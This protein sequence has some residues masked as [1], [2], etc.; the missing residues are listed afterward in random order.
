MAKSVYLENKDRGLTRVDADGR[1]DV[2]RPPTSSR[3][4]TLASLAAHPQRARYTIRHV[5]N[6]VIRNVNDHGCMWSIGGRIY[7]CIWEP[8]I[9][10]IAIAGAVAALWVL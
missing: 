7:A 4:P 6:A 1:H 2:V 10:V 5:P 9:R 3:T 8:Y